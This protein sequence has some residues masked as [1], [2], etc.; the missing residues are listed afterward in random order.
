M[1]EKRCLNPIRL[2]AEFPGEKYYRIDREPVA[3]F[4]CRKEAG[5]R[6]NHRDYGAITC[7]HVTQEYVIEWSNPNQPLEESQTNK[8][9]AIESDKP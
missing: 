6:G 1:S 4:E 2:N 3:L 9:K 5:H 8:S 7:G